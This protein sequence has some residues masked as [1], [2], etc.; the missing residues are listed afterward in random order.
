MFTVCCEEMCLKL[1]RYGVTSSWPMADVV[2]NDEFD[3]RAYF[4]SAGPS[5]P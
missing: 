2:V 1:R 4:V 3:E 5:S